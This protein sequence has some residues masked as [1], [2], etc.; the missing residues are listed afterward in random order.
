MPN[1][2]ERKQQNKEKRASIKERRS[3]RNKHVPEGV[4]ST[5]TGQEKNVAEVAGGG[6]TL[7]DLVANR[8]H[9]IK[10]LTFL[11]NFIIYVCVDQPE[12]PII[13]SRF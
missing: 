12:I 6:S 5:T 1:F 7:N 2:C 11:N 8:E 13:S 4:L 10:P 9:E 3:A